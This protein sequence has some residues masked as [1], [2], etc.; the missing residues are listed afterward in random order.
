MKILQAVFLFFMLF[1]ISHGQ[2]WQKQNID[3]KASLRG[4]AVVDRNVVWASGTGG[5]VLRTMDGGQNWSVIKVPDA[6]KLDFRDVEA[7]DANTAYILSIGEGENS[8]IY[9]TI[10]GGKTWKLQFKNTNPKAFFDAL[11]F[12]DKTNGMAM[13]DPVDGK[14][15]LLKTT[16]GET[17]TI[18]GNEKM[19]NAKTGEAAFAASGTCLL[20][21]GKQNVFL[22]SGGADARVFRSESRG[23]TWTVSA[24]PIVNGT[25]GS[26]IFSIAM[27]DAKN[28]VIVG[29][30]YEKPD[31]IT[32]NLAFTI[33]GGKTWTLSKGLNGYRS[34]V[35]YIDKKTII[36]VGASGSDL[37]TDGGKTWINLDRENYNAVAAKGKAAIWAVGA[38]GSVAKFS[39]K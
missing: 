15:V 18:S 7:F 9:K 33:D 31:E 5:T 8:R 20:T 14:Y 23:E 4:L 1:T 19:A 22:V 35:A 32:N 27:R 2:T 10:D 24:T 37:S 26:G 30:N 17:W 21:H 28:G 12:W 39:L 3:T 6:E 25:P 13:S 34:G 38:N 29:G 16:D 11:A 36:A